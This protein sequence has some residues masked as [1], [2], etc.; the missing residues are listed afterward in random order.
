[1]ISP[2]PPTITTANMASHRYTAGGADHGSSGF[3]GFTGQH[4]EQ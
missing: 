3:G 1:M 4:F 2:Q